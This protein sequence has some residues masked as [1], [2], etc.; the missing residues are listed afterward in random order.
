MI[1]KIAILPC[2]KCGKQVEATLKD[3]ILFCY[4]GKSKI[5]VFF[6]KRGHKIERDVG[7]WRR[8]FRRKDL[9]EKRRMGLKVEGRP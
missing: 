3:E 4:K 5:Q 1:G 8:P 7:R 9:M 6:C 2:P